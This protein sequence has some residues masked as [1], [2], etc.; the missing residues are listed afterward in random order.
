MEI[1]GGIG[2]VEIADLA[3]DGQR[4]LRE[5][6][7]AHLGEQPIDLEIADP[8]I[9][10]EDAVGLEILVHHRR[11][12]G[13]VFVQVDLERCAAAIDPL[14]V[15]VLFLKPA[16]VDRDVGDRACEDVIA[17]APEHIVDVARV[18]LVEGD[19]AEGDIVADRKVD[20]SVEL[21]ADAAMRDLVDLSVEAARGHPE[22]G[23]VGDDADGAGL[24]RGA[25]ERALRPR[26]AFD[27]GDVVDMDIER[28]ADGRHRLFVEV[29]AD[30]RQRARVV[31]VA[32]GRDP[33]HVDGGQAGL[34]GLEADRR[35]LLGI[36]LEVGDVELVEAAGADRLN[37]DR[38]VLKVFL[39][40]GRGDDDFGRVLG[41]SVT[42]DLILRGRG[43]V[44]R[45]RRRGC[46]LGKGRC[47]ERGG[48]E[49][50]DYK[51]I[52]RARHVFFPCQPQTRLHLASLGQGCVNGAS[53]NAHR[54][55]QWRCNPAAQ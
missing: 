10:A 15:E 27:P 8:G 39:A 17:A 50:A 52:E 24:A 43:G 44:A 49:Q 22:L 26:E 38:N 48:R 9:V 30:A 18:L 1:G 47:C 34:G 14:V 4:R 12:D 7:L 53:G 13:P 36:I 11:G 46:D 5:L 45:F 35:Q 37:R 31:A 33:A 16:V 55:C 19:P 42:G 25:V 29:G 40:L 28:P 41:L 51:P 6:V 21:A 54:L 23:L 20:H 3:L 32:A 2:Q